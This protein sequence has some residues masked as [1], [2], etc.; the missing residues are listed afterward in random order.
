MTNERLIKEL[1]KYDPKST[2]K[3][4]HH[5]YG[6]DVVFVLGYEN[7]SSVITLQSK[8]DVDAPVWL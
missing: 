1:Q 8:D 4:H 5:K 3:L 6:R 7:D 2:V